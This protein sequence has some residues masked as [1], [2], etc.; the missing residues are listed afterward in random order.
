VLQ[1]RMKAVKVALIALAS[2]TLLAMAPVCTA[3]D[4]ETKP[5]E[6]ATKARSALRERLQQVSQQL[7]LT[8]EQKEKL[9]PIFK[10]QAGK[11]RE[12]RANKDLSREDRLVKAKAIREDL[13]AK[14]KP[15]LTPEQ[16]EKWNKLRSEGPG[17]RRQE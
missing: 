16:L 6:G 17:R 1:D 15:I 14:V 13:E 11:V 2:G 10:E 8:D 9:R 4:N 3:A 7:K 12:L 5:S